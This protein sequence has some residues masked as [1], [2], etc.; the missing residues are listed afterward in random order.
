MIRNCRQQHTDKKQRSQPNRG[1]GAELDPGTPGRHASSLALALRV[2]F[3]SS[4]DDTN[5][6][7]DMFL[8]FA[9]K[10]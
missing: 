10:F 7:F 3:F 1:F 6:A 9:S 4:F 8:S 2:L 5:P